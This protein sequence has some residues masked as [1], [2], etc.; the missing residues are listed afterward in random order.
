LISVLNRADFHQ[1]VKCHTNRTHLTVDAELAKIYC[2]SV[3]DVHID[4]VTFDR[5][6]AEQGRSAPYPRSEPFAV[7]ET[8]VMVG[9]DKDLSQVPWN[10]YT[11]FKHEWVCRTTH[12]RA[13]SKVT[14]HFLCF[15]PR[16]FD[17]YFTIRA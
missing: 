10:Q 3:I 14:E 6:C 8:E 5:S 11:L 12:T 9:D 4:T 7:T 13:Y 2:T 17:M 16:R 15:L 1:V